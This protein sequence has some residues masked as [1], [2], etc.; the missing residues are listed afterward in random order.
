M[1]DESDLK[2]KEKELIA[3]AYEVGDM[4]SG[5]K[6][7]DAK[8]SLLLAAKKLQKADDATQK[9]SSMK[10]EEQDLIQKAYKV[11]DMPSGSDKDDAKAKL[12]NEAKALDAEKKNTE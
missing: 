7:D 9:L 12:I 2:Q 3:V 10:N 8:G 5:Q 11:R 4:P 6:K 1:G